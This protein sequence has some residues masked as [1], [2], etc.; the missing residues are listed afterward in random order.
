MTVT[1]VV[2]YPGAG[3]DPTHPTFAAI[4]AACSVP[5][6]RNAFAYRSKGKRP[7]PAASTLVTEVQSV[8][9]DLCATTGDPA[10]AI[11]IGG[12]S[13]GG[14]IASMAVAD[15]TDAAGLLLLSY[16]LHPPA[17][18]EKLRIDHF[19]AITVPCLFISGTKDPFGTPD[20][21]A[22]HTQAIGGPVTMHWLDGKGHDPKGCDGEIAE[23]V[24]AW[25]ADL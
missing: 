24:V 3:G 8:V 4:E 14:R 23:R 22:R 19:A 15:G 25:L 10:R 17:K 6:H 20:E 7:P 21:F 5:V 1:R 13:M 11:A 16:P 9:A 18:P 12:R 2:L